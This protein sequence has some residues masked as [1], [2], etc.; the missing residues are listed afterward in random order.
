MG[1][2]IHMHMGYKDKEVKLYKRQ[3]DEVFI[4]EGRNYDLFDYIQEHCY[5]LDESLPIPNP[6]KKQYEIEKEWCFSFK[7][8]T[9]ADMA[10]HIILHEE[11]ERTEDEREGFEEF[12][13]L[14]E[15]AKIYFNFWNDEDYDPSF[16]NVKLYMWFDN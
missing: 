13:D 10:L 12:K 6:I 11:D 2:D 14:F 16:S 1:T 9:L 4:Y 3:G 5:P 15:K 8:I 7:E